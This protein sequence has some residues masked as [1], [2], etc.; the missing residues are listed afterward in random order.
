MP[1]VS[2]LRLLFDIFDTSISF[3]FDLVFM[4]SFLI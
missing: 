2:Y 3:S 1:T 4:G